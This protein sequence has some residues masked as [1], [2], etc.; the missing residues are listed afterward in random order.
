M[1][2]GRKLICAIIRLPV[3]YNPEGTGARRRI[4]DSKFI[5]TAKEISEK[6]GGG[7]LFRWEKGKPKG[8]WWDHGVL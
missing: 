1:T 7:T 6:F 4:E 2:Q 5:E 8:F 3:E